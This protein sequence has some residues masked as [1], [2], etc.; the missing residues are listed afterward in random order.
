MGKAMKGMQGT[1]SN[2]KKTLRSYMQENPQRNQVMIDMRA[3]ANRKTI[4]HKSE[5]LLKLLPLIRLWFLH[6]NESGP[7]KLGALRSIES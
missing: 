6:K 4:A 2:V 3:A 7:H 5:R 1:I